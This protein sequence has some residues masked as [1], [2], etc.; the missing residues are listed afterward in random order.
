MLVAHPEVSSASVFGLPSPLM[1]EMVAAAITLQAGVEQC[2]PEGRRM[3]ELQAWCR[4]RLAE[5]KVPSTV[6]AHACSV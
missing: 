5:Y 6:G 4:Q 2:I 1:G 3:Q